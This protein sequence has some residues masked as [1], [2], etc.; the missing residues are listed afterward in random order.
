MNEH[1]NNGLNKMDDYLRDLLNNHQ[2]EPSP[3]L[4]AKFKVRLFKQD[5]S[6]FVRFKKFKKAY[7]PHYKSISLQVKLWTS[8]A[9]AACLAIGFVFGSSYMISNFI[10]NPSPKKDKLNLPTNLSP[11][12]SEIKENKIDSS[13]SSVISVI[14]EDKNQDNSISKI[15]SN[16]VS[17][18]KVIISGKNTS[19]GNITSDYTPIEKTQPIAVNNFSTLMNYIQK[20]NPDTKIT[21]PKKTIENPDEIVSIENDISELLKDTLE[22]QINTTQYKIEIPNVITPNGDGFNDVFIIKNLDKFDDNSLIIADRAGNVVLERNSYQ[23]D[24]DAQNIADGTYYYI[25]SYK[26]KKNGKNI[27]KGLITIRRK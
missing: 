12:N 21:E 9:A 22:N 4:W 18:N 16:S 11:L 3:N 15:Q 24:W 20:L 23:N 6:E 26:D 8:Y 14:P 27:I 17:T 1:L 10:N 19:K 7:N 5:V 2:V 13:K 25:L